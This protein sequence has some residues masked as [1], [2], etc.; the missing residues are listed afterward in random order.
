MGISGPFLSYFDVG[1]Q[2]VI[3]VCRHGSGGCLK[4]AVLKFLA[5][6]ETNN[7]TYHL[8]Q[9]NATKLAVSSVYVQRLR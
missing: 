7:I 9:V 4:N 6:H 5:K 2:H 3:D 8:R 1:K